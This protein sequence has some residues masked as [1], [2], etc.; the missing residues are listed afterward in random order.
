MAG[1]RSSHQLFLAL[2]VLPLLFVVRAPGQ[3]GGQAGLN[4]YFPPI[5]PFRTG[6]LKVDDQHE[7]YYEISGNPLGHPVMV[8]HGGP[9]GG[10][11]PAL[12]RYHDPDK[13]QIIL[14]DQRGCGKSR[15]QY[16]LRGNTTP[17][18]VEDMEKLRKELDVEKMQIVGGSWGSTLALAYAEKYP[19]RVGSLVLRGLFLATKAEIDHFY[20]G[21]VAEYFPE[22]Y[23]KLRSVIPKPKEMNYPRQLLDLLQKGDEETKKRIAR[24]WAA[25]ETKIGALVT[26]DAEVESI[27]NEFDA[28]AFA[29][30][31]NYYMANRCFLEEGELLKNAGKLSG[32]PTVIC[33]GRYDVICTPRAAFELGRALPGSK[34]VIVEA[35]GHSGSA[36][37]MRSAIIGA[38]NWLEPQVLS[39]RE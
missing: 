35:A 8:L 14:F 23:E 36:P 12:R 28:Y 22:V 34:L 27:L 32:I 9:G 15:P 3:S 4:D 38:I 18:L 37:L 16:E 26:S 21:A 17:N 13:Y 7:I 29:L 6:F 39:P 31:E 5:E 2:F 10:S 19:E 25:Y 20:H 24:A 1:R 11:Y 30:I 33:H